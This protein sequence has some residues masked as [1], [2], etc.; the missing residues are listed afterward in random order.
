VVFSESGKL[1]LEALS[2]LSYV[3]SGFLTFFQQVRVTNIYGWTAVA[4]V[5]ATILYVF[6]RS[7]LDLAKSL[8]TGVYQVRL[9]MMP[10]STWRVDMST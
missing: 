5:I 3:N 9:K 1:M 7:F 8:V 6:G 4:I 10:V 2:T